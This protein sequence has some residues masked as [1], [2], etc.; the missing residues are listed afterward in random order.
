MP[1][2]SKSSSNFLLPTLF[3]NLSLCSEFPYQ[4]SLQR[5]HGDHFC[6]GSI[7]SEIWVVTAAHCHLD[8]P[9]E[10]VAGEHDF[11]RE[12][13]REQRRNVVEFTVHENYDGSVGPDDI[14]V[15]KM[16]NPLEFNKYVQPINLPEAH[17]YPKGRALLSGWGSISRR[18]GVY[19]NILQ[20]ANLPIH[21]QS[22][23]KELWEGSPYADTNVCAGP[24][25]GSQAS[26]S[27]DSGGPLAQKSDDVFTLVGVVSWGQSKIS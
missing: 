25:S 10:V 1:D 14:A 18:P 23:C 2:Q 8:E 16:D 7:I 17:T 4:I 11:S 13:G 9:I 27:G 6:G 5:N 20:K 21:P 3:Q 12:T 22:K 15:V 26:C 19:P 24:L